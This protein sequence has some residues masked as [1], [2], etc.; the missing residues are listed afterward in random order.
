MKYSISLLIYFYS[1]SCLGQQTVN[2][3]SPYVATDFKKY[4]YVGFDN[5]IH[6]T[7]GNIK[8]LQ[9]STDNG[10]I[11]STGKKGSFLI[12]P[13]KAG[14]ATITLSGDNFKKKFKFE[15]WP[16]HYPGIRL[17][18]QPNEDG[19]IDIKHN[20]AG[21]TAFISPVDV[22]FEFQI[23]SFT[24]EVKDSLRSFSHT[25]IGALWDSVTKQWIQDA[26]TGTRILIYNVYMSGQGRKKIK[27]DGYLECYI[28]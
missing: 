10:S 18:G 14:T 1:L 4:L 23:D 24:V 16:M 5:P 13:E 28:W 27:S 8:L 3:P 12:K 2:N 20:S 9:V 22:D 26:K 11:V 6:I 19:M 25:N 7:T 21:I 15:V 17:L